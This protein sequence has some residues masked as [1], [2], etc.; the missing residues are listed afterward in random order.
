MQQH[1]RP[2]LVQAGARGFDL[3]D[4]PD[5]LRLFGVRVDH[6]RELGL[7]VIELFA[8]GAQLRNCGLKDRI[9]PG[10]LIRR[11]ADLFL[12]FVVLPPSERL[13]AKRGRQCYQQQGG[14]NPARD[15]R[16]HA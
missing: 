16:P 7:E 15:K 1:Q 6:L 8:A 10:T 4:L 11:Q 12:E 2:H 5:D 3:I 13:C 9:D 14:R